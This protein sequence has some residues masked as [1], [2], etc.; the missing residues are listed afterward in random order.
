MLTWTGQAK[1]LTGTVPK[2]PEYLINL[3]WDEDASVWVATSD[4]IPGLT[5]PYFN[6]Q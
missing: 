4:D 6:T 3:V 5:N 2:T 1:K